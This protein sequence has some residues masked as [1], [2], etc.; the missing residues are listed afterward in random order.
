MGSYWCLNDQL[1]PDN[2]INIQVCLV[3]LY[4][5]AIVTLSLFLTQVKT[6]Y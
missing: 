3:A 4:P 6:L 5:A 2:G 1:F